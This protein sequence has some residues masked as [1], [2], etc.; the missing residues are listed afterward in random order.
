MVNDQD[1][2]RQ[3]VASIFTPGDEGGN[4]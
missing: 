2:T 3:S 4:Q 1:P